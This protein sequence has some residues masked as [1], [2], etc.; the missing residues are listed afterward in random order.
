MGTRFEFLIPSQ[1]HDDVCSEIKKI[2]MNC[3]KLLS[4]FD[5]R[6]EIFRLNNSAFARPKHVSDEVYD[7]LS[8][9]SSYYT[10]TLT[11]FDIG[12]AAVFDFLKSNNPKPEE[13]KSLI[14]KSGCKNIDFKE[15][16]IKFLTPDVKIDLGAV[17]KGYALK[18]VDEFLTENN[19]D[20][21]FISFGESSVLTRGHHPKG[22]HWKIGI[23]SISEENDTS[24]VFTTNNHSVSTSSNYLICD[25]SNEVNYNGHIISQNAEFG[26]SLKQVSVK[27]ESPIEAE[28]LSTALMACK[29]KDYNKIFCNFKGC[30]VIIAETNNEGDTKKLHLN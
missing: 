24:H 12:L 1:T 25:E 28:V 23:R 16:R 8:L 18:K 10:K 19:I 14:D 9:C 17:G 6:S 15:N 13:V 27:S 5:E 21:V 20:N 4:R 2:V 30:E 26:K 7:L 22:D 11:A 3:E 29:S